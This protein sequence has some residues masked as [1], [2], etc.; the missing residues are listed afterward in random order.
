VKTQVTAPEDS[1]LVIAG[2]N[3]R[4]L[5]RMLGHA[6]AAM[7]LDVYAGLFGDDRHAVADALDHAARRA[8]MHSG[9]GE[10]ADG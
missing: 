7:T 4:A 3:V 6:R 8:S 5:Q 10:A 2:A 1:S 9:P